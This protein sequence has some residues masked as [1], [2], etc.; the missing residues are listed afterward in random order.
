MLKLDLP[1]GEN[2]NERNSERNWLKCCVCGVLIQLANRANASQS[3]FKRVS[4]YHMHCTLKYTLTCKRT[5]TFTEEVSRRGRRVKDRQTEGQRDWW[6]YSN[7]YW[8]LTGT[9][10]SETLA[11]RESDVSQ[12]STSTR[13]RTLTTTYSSTHQYSDKHTLTP[14]A[15][16][17][18]QFPRPNTTTNSLKCF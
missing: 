4:K 18:L 9:Q 17:V 2:E 5:N 6:L 15:S 16:C 1:G 8:E 13:T 3:A 12:S 10:W 14:H 7:E 11:Q